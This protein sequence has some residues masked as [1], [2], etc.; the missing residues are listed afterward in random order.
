[1]RT[2]LNLDDALLARVRLLAAQRQTSLTHLIEEGLAMTLRAAQL[3]P[4]TR[5]RPPLPIHAGR[6]GLQ[7]AI[8]D[9]TSQRAILDALDAADQPG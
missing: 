4:V 7:P 9:A 2:T 8:R 1:M 3:P 5:E 6:G